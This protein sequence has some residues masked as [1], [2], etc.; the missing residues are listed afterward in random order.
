MNTRT[1]DSLSCRVVDAGKL[2]PESGGADTLCDVIR[3]AAAAQE[4]DD[5]FAVEVRVLSPAALVATVTSPDGRRLPD[6]R[7]ASS[8]REL[9][10]SSFERFAEALVRSAKAQGR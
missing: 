5:G 10:K 6:Q 8:D 7:M 4:L 2:P 3:K 1:G 9:R